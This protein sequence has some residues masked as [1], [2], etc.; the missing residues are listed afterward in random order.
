M[1]KNG[2]DG[3]Y[4]ADPKKDP[5]ARRFDHVTYN[6]AMQRRLQVMDATAMSLCMENGLPI[7][8]FDV[9]ENESIYRALCGER[10]GTIVS[11]QPGA[12]PIRDVR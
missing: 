5:N 2:V 8:V 4:D 9:H 11:A 3:V 7:V 1:A 12:A 10:I 6:D